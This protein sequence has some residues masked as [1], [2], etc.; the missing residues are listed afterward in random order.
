MKKLHV[1]SSCC[2]ERI[3]LFGER[4]RQCCKCKKTWRVRRKQVGRKKKRG[5]K[6]LLKRFF[7]HAIGSSHARARQD[8]SIER[9]L[10]RD[11][12]RSRDLFL[13]TTGWGIFPESSNV[14]LIADARI[15]LIRKQWYTLYCIMVRGPKGNQAIIAPPVLLLGLETQPGWRRALDTLPEPLRARVRVI[16]CDGHRGTV[17]YAKQAGWLIQRC[18]F[19]LLAAIQ[20]R[21]SRFAKSRHREEGERVHKLVN[22]ALYHHDESIVRKALCEIDDLAI[23]TTSPQLRKVL[24]GFVNNYEDFRTYLHHTDLNLPTTSNTAESLIGMIHELCHRMR[25]FSST[26]AFKK[27]TEAL[28]K[29]KQTITCNG[30]NQ[31][32]KCR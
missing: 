7:D 6:L 26:G 14:I 12:E 20:G 11:I 10:Q 28:L 30:R 1:K 15:G 5:S 13:R 27:W 24:D 8:P 16:V 25:G 31:P 18:H 29:Y 17:N 19:H 22:T 2:R 32:R 9:N 21:R 3:R 4:R 23:S